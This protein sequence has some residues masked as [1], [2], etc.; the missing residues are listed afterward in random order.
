M[1]DPFLYRVTAVVR[2][3]DS[4]DERSDRCGFRDFRFEDG[5]F[6][7]NGRRLF[8]R[9]AHTVN[10]TPVGQ[11]VPGDP[12]LFQRDLLYMRT[13]GFNCIRFIWGARHDGS[14]VCAM[15][16]ACSC[17]TSTRLEPLRGYPA[18]SRAVR[19]VGD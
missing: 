19:P 18:G 8:L 15:S 12:A 1:A 16:W 17:M 13:M 4:A 10:A 5:H 6:R 9:G 2:L 3:G 7:L 11:Q 14:S